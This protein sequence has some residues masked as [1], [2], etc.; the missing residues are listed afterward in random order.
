MFYP[1]NNFYQPVKTIQK[2]YNLEVKHV[3]LFSPFLYAFIK[4]LFS[5]RT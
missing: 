4:H 5:D 1:T 2:I 3:S